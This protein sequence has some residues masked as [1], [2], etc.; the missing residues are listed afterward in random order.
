MMVYLSA[1]TFGKVL[2]YLALLALVSPAMA[3][4]CLP[5]VLPAWSLTGY[6]LGGVAQMGIRTHL[7]LQ[8]LQSQ[9]EEANQK[10]M[11]ARLYLARLLFFDYWQVVVGCVDDHLG[12]VVELVS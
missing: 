7:V 10:G 2:L 9:R 12:R 3:S 4:V 1:A 6:L 5:F 8:D 11:L